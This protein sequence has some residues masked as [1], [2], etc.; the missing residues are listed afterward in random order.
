MVICTASMPKT[1]APN[2]YTSIGIPYIFAR[3]RVLIVPSPYLPISALAFALVFAP[4]SVVSL[5]CVA[6]EALFSLLS[7]LSR[8]G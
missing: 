6:H 1:A 5:L 7:E 2:D 8:A 3:A 4:A